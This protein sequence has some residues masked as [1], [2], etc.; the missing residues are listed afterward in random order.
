M[1]TLSPLKNVCSIKECPLQSLLSSL[2]LNGKSLTRVHCHFTFQ[3][4]FGSIHRLTKTSNS[5]LEQYEGDKVISY[6]QHLTVPS[7]LVVERSPGVREVV[8][9]IL[10]QVIPKTLN[11]VLDASWLSAQHLKDRSRTYGQFPHCRL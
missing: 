5:I 8:G 11:M 3:C 1:Y 9:L 2:N 10:G 4:S 7:C 6:L